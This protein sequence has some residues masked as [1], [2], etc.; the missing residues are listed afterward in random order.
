MENRTDSE[1]LDSLF[2]IPREPVKQFLKTLL[3]LV[4][5]VEVTGLENVPQT[6]GA[7]LISNHT[8]HLDVIVQGT[9]V[10]RKVIYLGKYELFHPQETILEFL[11]NPDSPL[12]KFPLSLMKQTL[13]TALNALGDLQGKQLM[14]WGGHPI[15]R[16]HNVKDA[17]SAAA[18]YEDLENYIVELIGKGELISV[19]PEGTRTETLEPGAFKA[20]S[21]KLAIRAGVPIIPSGIKGAW[22]MT[23]P[24]AFLTGKAFGSKVTY[25]IGKPIYPHEFPKEPLKKAAKMVTE[26][27]ER[28]V[29]K[30]IEEP[31]T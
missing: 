25:N 18:Y 6:G 7:V 10:A 12:N 4:Y 3:N 20:L 16:S 13:V 29:R 9:A 2:L 23:K 31:E 24:E 8:D 5:S 14:H 26:E 30:L 27:L 17:K 28:R 21:A 1:L 22:R 11:E 19:Y 15:L